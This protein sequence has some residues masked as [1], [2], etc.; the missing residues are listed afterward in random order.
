MPELLNDHQIETSLS[1][2]IGWAREG[3]TLVREWKL[4]DF[5]QALHFINEVGKLA[6]AADH[7]P[8]ILLHGWNKV[9]IMLSTHS[10]GGITTNDVT[11]A[12]EIGAVTI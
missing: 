7:H 8:D 1:Q 3:N 11:L 9:K 10:K 12:R 4:K 5:A 6:E 2:L